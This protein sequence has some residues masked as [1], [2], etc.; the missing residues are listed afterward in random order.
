MSPRHRALNALSARSAGQ[1]G[2]FKKKK[3]V[4]VA[5]SGGVD[6]SVATAI[7][8]KAGFEVVG[9]FMRFWRDPVLQRWNRC[10]SPEA[11]KRA[12]RVAL[13]LGIPFYVLDFGKE[14][15]KRIVN[16][17]LKEHK[18]NFTPNPC[19]VCNK[20]IKFGLLLE[21]ALDI[22][23]DYVATGHY[24][25]KQ[26]TRFRPVFRSKT[27]EGD[28]GPGLQV[29][30]KIYKLLRAKD[31]E[32]DQSYF[33]WQLSQKQLKKILFPLENLTKK[34]VISLARKFK[35]PVLNIP[36][37]QEICFIQTTVNDFLKRYLKQKPGPIV[38][39]A[40]YRAS[41]IIDAKR[42][43]IGQH[44]GL[45]FYTIGQRRGIRLPGGPY[46]VLDKDLK[47]NFLVVTKNER[48]L[49]KKELVAGNVHWI[50]GKKPKLP[51]RVKSKVRY[52]QEM[53]PAII[54]DQR[55]KN[56]KQ[57]LVEFKKPQRAITLG[58]SVV[59]YREKELL[60][61]GIIKKI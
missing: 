36:E 57:V 47:R 6:S 9:V 55:I 60:G 58:Q 39:Q 7:L 14:F 12:R 3:K 32:K 37:S 53:M 45:A 5:M 40:H 51:L 8:K 21:K 46:F 19:V 56:K 13:L 28:Q 4:L 17:F 54:K 49:Y 33:L 2:R 1:A 15:K 31:K 30:N 35:L 11:E 27:A 24:V 41:K 42:K 20:E 44:Q 59:F 16:Y 52:R 50:S 34:E 29:K 22:G 38:E 25:K 48:D 23:A 18:K 43:I 10:C 61:G 26:E